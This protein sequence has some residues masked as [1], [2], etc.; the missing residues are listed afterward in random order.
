[1]ERALAQELP[2][3]PQARALAVVAT[4]AWQ[5]GYFGRAASLLDR[6]ERTAR[7]VGDP[8]VLAVAILMRVFVAISR[9]ERAR[10]DALASEGGAL[11]RTLGDRSGEGLALV[12]QAHI[13]LARGDL[14]R[15][16]EILGEAEAVLREAG[17]WHGLTAD[18]I[19]WALVA[20]LRGD[21]ARSVTLLRKSLEISRMLRDMQTLG[22]ALEG[23]AGTETMLG[24]SERAARLFGASEALRERTGSAVQLAAWRELHERHLAAL[25]VQ[26]D[27]DELAVAWAE[28]RAMPFEQAVAY[29]LETDEAS[30]T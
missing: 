25:R 7:E 16:E 6:V 30:L 1:M 24:R 17:E 18:L 5:Q 8:E 26:L 21:Y 19:I 14:T 28:G 29:A 22:Y 9:G 10:A 20:Q 15:A 27:A 11:Y 4:L 2:Q 23:T 13:A 12:T 3:G